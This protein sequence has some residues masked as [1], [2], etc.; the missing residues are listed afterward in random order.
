MSDG[1]IEV[2][3]WK[4]EQNGLTLFTKLGGYT[5]I[6]TRTEL[7]AAVV[8]MAAHAPIHLASDSQAF[9]QS[10]RCPY[11]QDGQTQRP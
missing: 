8:S 2:A 5:G 7:A 11:A 3:N 10:C 4:Q 9:C 1:E 6:S